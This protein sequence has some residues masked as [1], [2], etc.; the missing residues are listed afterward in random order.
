MAY[1]FWIGSL[2]LLLIGMI[3]IGRPSSAQGIATVPP[4]NTKRATQPPA[5]PRI[6]IVTSTPLP[7]KAAI[8]ARLC[9][10]CQR[11]RLRE[12]PGSAGQVV[13][14]LDPLVTLTVLA[15]SDDSQWLQVSVIDPSNT[16]SSAGSVTGWVSVDFV[17]GQDGQPLDADVIATYPS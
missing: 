1:R 6:I 7:T 8:P 4:T 14:F 11:V 9:G 3:Y 10:D 2:C 5:T 13:E 17:R 12:T 15:R 16:D